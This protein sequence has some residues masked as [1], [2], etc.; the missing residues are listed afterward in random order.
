ML[1]PSQVVVNAYGTPSMSSAHTRPMP[2]LIWHG[3]VATVRSAV[4]VIKEMRPASN[5][6][7]SQGTRSR[8]AQKQ[9][10]NCEDVLSQCNK[11]RVS[12][13]LCHATPHP[14]IPTRPRYAG[15]VKVR[16]LPLPPGGTIP[17]GTWRYWEEWRQAP[18]SAR[19]SPRRVRLR[20]RPVDQQQ[21]LP[22]RPGW[23]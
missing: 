8:S 17:G 9:R 23:Q 22:Q 16:I 6:Y 3:D 20:L 15:I 21:A 2:L 11:E 14:P 1:A 7:I 19:R 12:R 18:R 10:G 5:V 4:R 13:C